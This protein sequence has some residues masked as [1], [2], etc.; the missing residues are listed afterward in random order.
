[1]LSIHM[2]LI[3]NVFKCLFSFLSSSC[4]F[5]CLSHHKLFTITADVR[6]D[7]HDTIYPCHIWDRYYNSSKNRLS[8]A[9]IWT[10]DLP[11]SKP[12]SQPL[13]YEDLIPSISIFSF[14]IR[15]KCFQLVLWNFFERSAKLNQKLADA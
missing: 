8:L 1:M 2:K 5:T 13:S 11:G 3:W 4:F 15:L 12:P 14:K 7:T 9:R 6:G 10:Q